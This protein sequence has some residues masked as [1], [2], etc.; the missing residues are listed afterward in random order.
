[1]DGAPPESQSRSS[2]TNLASLLAFLERI[3]DHRLT[4]RLQHIRDAIMVCVDVPGERWE[5]EF[6]DDGRVEVERFISTGTIE[7]ENLLAILIEKYTD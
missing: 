1:V 4:Y 3:G 6:F 5:I 2:Q 7:D